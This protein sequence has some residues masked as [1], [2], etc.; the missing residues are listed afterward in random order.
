MEIAVRGQILIAVRVENLSDVLNC[1]RGLFGPDMIKRAEIPEALVAPGTS[2]FAL[3]TRYVKELKLK[4]RGTR[5]AR[6]GNGYTFFG[7]Y[8]PVRLAVLDR[9]CSVDVIKVPDGCP[10]LIGRQPLQLLDLTIDEANQRI[11][12]NPEHEGHPMVDVF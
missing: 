10:V 9:E 5:K 7:I 1:S 3:P 2:C 11:V 6:T 8:E 4:R 12:G